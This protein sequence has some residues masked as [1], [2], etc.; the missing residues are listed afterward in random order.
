MRSPV[1]WNK[2]I[3]RSAIVI[4]AGMP[5]TTASA[6]RRVPRKSASTIVTTTAP[7][8][9]F[10]LTVVSVRPTKSLRS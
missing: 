4:D 2:C 7:S 10:S 8:T 5:R 1:T 3:P 6:P 9:R